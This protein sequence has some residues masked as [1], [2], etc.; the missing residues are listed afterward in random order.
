LH[1]LV[2]THLIKSWAPAATPEL[3][4]SAK[5]ISV[6]FLTVMCDCA[7]ANLIQALN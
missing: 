7:A 3:D 6:V 1:L 4:D 5:L 2:R